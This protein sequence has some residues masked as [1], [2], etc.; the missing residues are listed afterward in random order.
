MARSQ[1]LGP[2]VGLR[3]TRV[4]WGHTQKHL[5]T[6]SIWHLAPHDLSIALEILGAIPT[7]RCATADRAKKNAAWCFGFLGEDPWFV[8]EVSTRHHEY[9][10]EIV[11]QCRDGIVALSNSYSDHLLIR[12]DPKSNHPS[13]EA[14][15]RSISMEFPL[16]R[17]LRTFVEHLDGGPSPRSSAAEG[18]AIVNT[19]ATLRELAGLQG[20]LVE[21]N[22]HQSHHFGSHP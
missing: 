19:I 7:P 5:D 21:S 20:G 6:D 2:V 3:T 11:L 9:R 17:E 12:R 10:R 16:L 4:G 18:A 14:Q 1:E 8:L 22:A 15:K 13:N